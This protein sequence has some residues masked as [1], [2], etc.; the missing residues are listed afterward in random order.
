MSGHSKWSTIRHKKGAAD[1][2]RGKVF[3]KII[4]EITVAARLGGG[5][6][7]GNPRLRRAMD[8]AKSHNMPNDNVV[9]AV[10]KGTGELDGVNYEELTYE[11]VG[12]G[13][14]LFAI[15]VVTDNR[16]RTAPEIRKI[17]ERH[18]GQ[19]GSAG[20]ALWAFDDKGVVRLPLEAAGEE[21]IFE[22]AVNAGADDVEALDDEWVVTTPRDGLDEVRE[23]LERAAIKVTSTELDRSARNKK[24]VDAQDAETL[25]KLI[26]TL[27]DHDDVQRVSSDFELSQAALERLATDG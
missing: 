18:N 24:H 4:K 17:F 10:K 7:D 1:A 21:R 19:L 2:K 20:S 6:A 15:D 25:M 11:G 13:G 26:D 8:L 16:N 5:D 9:R 12:P 27:E 23:A 22:V 3:T 14:T